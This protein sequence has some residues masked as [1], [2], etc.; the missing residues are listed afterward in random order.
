MFAS[1]HYI[2]EHHANADIPG[3][4]YHG[5]LGREFEPKPTITNGVAHDADGLPQNSQ[6]AEDD[7]HADSPEAI[8]AALQEI[9]KDLVRKEQRIE[10]LISS[11]PGSY[12]TQTQ[13][14]ERM[15][16][17]SEELDHMDKHLE[18]AAKEKVHLLQRVESVIWKVNRY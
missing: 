14:E 2:A 4:Q 7:R 17:L 5:P 18:D 12:H 16:Q 6:V 9:A 13:Q 11:L 15:R 10:T 8:N 3:Q 1:L